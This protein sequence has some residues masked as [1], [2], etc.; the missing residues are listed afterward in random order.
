META[1]TTVGRRQ[2]DY[3]QVENKITN[4]LRDYANKSG[5]NGYVI[6]VSGGIDSAVVSTLCALTGLPLTCV[7][8][9]IHQEVSQTER[10]VRHIQFLKS[11]FAN[12]DFKTVDLTIAFDD[13]KGLV[14][15]SGSFEG[16]SA[17]QEFLAMANTRS[18]LR[19]VA[20]YAIGNAHGYLVAGTG[21]KVEDYGVG[22]FT[23]FGDGGVDVSPIGQLTKTEVYEL[24]A[25]LGINQEILDARPTDGLWSDGRTDEDQIGATYPELEWAMEYYDSVD[26]DDSLLT[27]R[28]KEVLAIYTRRHEGNAH[29]MN[30]PPVC[31]I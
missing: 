22:F 6:G 15:A 7:V 17:D 8:M 29:K 11:K 30:M 19:M 13:M 21:N 26:K 14:G 16:V 5:L 20:L 10:G 23:K 24:A 1:T 27:E 28:Q 3:A 4:W 31:E 18:R 25:H 2:L 12:V 9:P